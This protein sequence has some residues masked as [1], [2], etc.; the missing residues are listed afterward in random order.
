MKNSLRYGVLVLMLLGC[1]NPLDTYSQAQVKID[2]MKL[3][4][5]QHSHADTLRVDLLN[6]I[7]FE[8]W[9]VDPSQSDEFGREAMQLAGKLGYQSGLAM[10][11]R[12]IGV[13]FWSRGDYFKSLQHLF[14]SQNTY[15]S[16]GDSL[17][18]ANS[19]MNIGLVYADEKD[20]GRALE[21]FQRAVQLFEQL[22]KTDRVGVTYNK[23]G[24]VYLD[25]GDLVSAKD[26]FTKGLEIHQAQNFSFGVMEA[27]NRLGLLYRELGDLKTAKSYLT[28]SLAIARKNSDREH[29][30]K[31]LENLASIAI[32]ERDMRPAQEYLDEATP[33]AQQYNYR[34]WLRDIY[35]DYK[36]IYEIQKDFPRAFQYLERYEAIK[37]SIFSEERASQIA[38]LE[39]EYQ[40]AQQEQALKLREQEILLLQQGV[41]LN[42]LFNLLLVAGILMI[43]LIGY[44]IFRNQRIRYKKKREALEHESQLQAVELANARALE[45]E[46]KESLEFKNRELTSYTVNFIRK[47]DLIEK[48]K[49]K[50][51]LLRVRMPDHSAELK[52]I[53]QLIQQSSTID[54]D[55]EDFKL[56][57]ENVHQDF[58]PRLLEH[59]SD[60]TQSELR[61][62]ALVSL[63]L[64]I[65]EMASLMGISPDSVK[66]ARYRLRKKLNL[67]QDQNLG[68]F[69]MG[70]A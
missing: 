1:L 43:V 36:E 59:C 28:S 35:F 44:L 53:S 23:I 8:Y 42:R 46:L 48:L 69:V 64:S 2:S 26:Y 20:Y 29:T 13:S 17:G 22:G 61:L 41:R 62:C 19:T 51:E 30:V 63:N 24:S 9:T 45:Q 3:L 25:K 7:G 27:S 49:E 31:N 12:V 5:N 50:L 14:E 34:K 21:N 38:N 54:K 6:Q 15:K 47:N 40:Q 11:H 60:L 16:I 57:F 52:S 39:R 66:T 70:F 37:D 65:K 4:L 33:L 55:W 56:T 58:F 18:E 68:D 32:R 67:D 10:A